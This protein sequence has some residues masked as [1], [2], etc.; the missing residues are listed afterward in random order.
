MSEYYVQKIKEV[1][2]PKIKYL[3]VIPF[4]DNLVSKNNHGIW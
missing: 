4:G 3:M 1:K 2:T